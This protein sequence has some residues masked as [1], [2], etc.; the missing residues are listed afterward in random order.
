MPDFLT[1]QEFS[2]YEFCPR[3]VHLSRAGVEPASLPIRHAV[4][5]SLVQAVRELARGESAASVA[6]EIPQLFME[7]ASNRG[8]DHA[9]PL[10]AFDRNAYTLIRDYACWLEGAV[11]LMDELAL[12][13]LPVDPVQVDR[14][15]I[16]LDCWQDRL[17]LDR[18]H[19]F[20]LVDRASADPRPK[21]LELLSS[22]HP[23]ICEIT[24]HSFILPSPVK[25]RLASPLVLAY[26]H[27]MTG[28][29]RLA[30]RDK[31]KLSFTQSWKRIARWET[32]NTGAIETILWPEWREGIERDQCLDRCY[33]EHVLDFTERDDTVRRDAI[34]IARDIDKGGGVRK[35]EMCPRCMMRGYCHGSEEERQSYR[36][37]TSATPDHSSPVTDPASSAAPHR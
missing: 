18:A 32:E 5:R 12:D 3:L 19:T 4:R 21:W 22:L 8:Y 15:P 26:A 1:A 11:Y 30:P 2:D 9:I 24:V 31:E 13:L 28:S 37:P 23:E 34:A 6:W 20:R 14:Y 36:V 29:L 35:R 17:H 25:D 33:M 27:P 16:A 10:L 7:E